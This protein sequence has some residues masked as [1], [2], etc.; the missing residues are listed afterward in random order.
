MPV[1]WRLGEQSVVRPHDEHY[2]AAQEG[3]NDCTAGTNL[4]TLQSERS[5]AQ[6]TRI[7]S[8]HLYEMSF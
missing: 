7:V 5:Q 3:N 2:S 1:S 4:K 6:R 8:F